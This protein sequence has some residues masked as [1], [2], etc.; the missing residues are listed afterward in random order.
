MARIILSFLIF[1]FSGAG[2]FAE[3]KLTLLDVTSLEESHFDC[4][5]LSG[6]QDWRKKI[7][8]PEARYNIASDS[9]AI[10]IQKMNRESIFNAITHANSSTYKYPHKDKA[11]KIF[12]KMRENMSLSDKEWY[13]WLEKDYNFSNLGFCSCG[14]KKVAQHKNN[15]AQKSDFNEVAFIK[16]SIFLNCF[17]QSV[18]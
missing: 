3:G 12:P 2:A 9:Q 13:A 1:V 16:K 11:K 5:T 18:N 15:L 8:I 14:A 4:A 17:F 10:F 6:D 7:L